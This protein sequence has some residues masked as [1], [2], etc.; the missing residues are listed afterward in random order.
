MADDHIRR[1]AI[2][3]RKRLVATIMSAAENSDWWSELDTREQEDFRAKVLRG[4]NTYHDFM[5]DVITVG[6]EDGS[7][8]EQVLRLLEQI[9]A[10][11]LRAERGAPVG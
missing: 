6:S 1:L 11:Q 3:Q 5:L 2:A 8:S 4:I 9:H 10:S 7:R